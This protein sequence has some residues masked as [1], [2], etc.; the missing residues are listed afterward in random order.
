[1]IGGVEDERGGLVDRRGAR[2]GRGIGNLPGVQ[3]QR[4][5]A[6]LA[7]SHAPIL[8]KLSEPQSSTGGREAARRYSDGGTPTWLRKKRVKL[9]CAEKPSSAETSPILPWPED[10]RAIAVSTHSMSRYA[11]GENPV[12]SW[13]RS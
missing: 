5:D 7:V 11:R 13:N 3:A 4:L 10:R 6:E 9:L 1:M 2:A 12:Q 8:A